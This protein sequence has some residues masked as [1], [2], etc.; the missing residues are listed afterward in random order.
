M[1]QPEEERRAAGTTVGDAKQ[2]PKVTRRDPEKRRLQNIRAQKKYREKKKQHLLQL[3]NLAASIVPGSA[4]DPEA[5]PAVPQAPPDAAP[6]QAKNVPET[7]PAA[8]LTANHGDEIVEPRLPQQPLQ[9]MEEFLVARTPG[10]S[11]SDSLVITAYQPGKENSL[12][13]PNVWEWDPSLPSGSAAFSNTWA[14][15]YFDCGCPV[16]H[17][18]IRTPA[19]PAQACRGRQGLA[20]Y[21]FFAADPYI[22]TLRIER[23]CIASA[24][25]SN[26]L[27]IGITDDT[28]CDEDS[29]SPFFRSPASSSSSVS[30]E[31][32]VRSVQSIFQTLKPDMRPC[33]EQITVSHHPYID[34]IPF[35]T[36]RANLIKTIDSIDE[37]E[38]FYDSL[39]GLICW[40]RA[41]VGRRDKEGVGSGTPWDVRSWEAKE[42]FIQKWWFIV[43]GEDGEL[44]RQSRWW[45]E[46]RGECDDALMLS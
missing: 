42:W 24:M 26:C 5:G 40:G 16:P 18:Q 23:L 1:N 39:N 38:F 36:V 21:N 13:S 20:P 2:R 12:W 8:Q 9:R 34:I 22:N 17:I 43:G 45:R 14:I 7:V 41:G 10:P 46:M 19:N 35:P 25:R 32:L 11:G 30:S 4:S 31:T 6:E 44:V 28:W 15:E 37:D 29:I 27:A 33:R 3:E